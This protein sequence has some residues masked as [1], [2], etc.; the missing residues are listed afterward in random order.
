M[1]NMLNMLNMLMFDTLYKNFSLG[2]ALYGFSRGFRSNYK[3]EKRKILTSERIINSCINSSIYVLPFFN[4]YQ[5]YK[6]F[7]RIE[8]DARQL[9]K[10]SYKELY[11]EPF[12]FSYSQLY[13]C[14][15]TL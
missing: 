1:L 9:D 3:N 7:N 5:L 6:L 14:K 12:D 4:L 15:Y 2:M 11:Q 8:V 13:E 10:E